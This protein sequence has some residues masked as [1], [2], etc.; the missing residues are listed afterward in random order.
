[1][2]PKKEKA[3][4]NWQNVMQNWYSGTRSVRLK[5]NLGGPNLQ[6]HQQMV[7]RHM[8]THNRIL[9][10]HGTGSGKTLMSVHVAEHYLDKDPSKNIVIFVTPAVVQPQFKRTAELRL[11]GRPGVYFT[12]YDGL[13]NF[14]NRLY[15]S[16]HETVRSIVKHA[17]IIADEAHYITEKTEKARVFYEVFS[18]ADKVLLMTGTPIQNGELKDLR[19]YAQILNPRMEVPKVLE[20]NFATRYFRCKVSIYSVPSTNNRF[21][22]L[23]PT[24]RVNIPLRQNQANAV[25]KTR[26][27]RYNWSSVIGQLSSSGNNSALTRRSGW[28]FNR[29]IYAKNVFP[30]LFS[31]P[32]F[33]KFYQIYRQRPYKTIVYFQQYVSMD[34]FKEFLK[35]RNIHFQEISGRANKTNKRGI[36]VANNRTVYLLTKAAKEGLDFKG[37]RSVIFMDYPWVPSDYNQIVGRARRFHSHVNLQPSNRNVMVYELAY[38]HQKP[39]TLNVRSLNILNTKRAKITHLMDQLRQVSIERNKGRCG[40]SPAR[41]RTASP[42]TANNR[43]KP[44]P[45]RIIV[46]NQ[47]SGIFVAV[48]PGGTKYHVANL[49]TPITKSVLPPRTKRNFEGFANMRSSQRRKK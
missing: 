13:T 46:R 19:P 34:R 7:V 15:K 11:S 37:V 42:P 22:T 48:S 8:D 21:P 25:G 36:N 14:L 40:S 10:V 27:G 31:E 2:P 5:G 23:R 9:A 33:E 47:P 30:N 28:A 49:N 35:S 17:L 43:L 44:R 29:N 26:A 39:K 3:E 20:P 4:S 6:S 18:H 38:T 45:N 24:Q 12:T 16:R 41:P 1:M 32:K